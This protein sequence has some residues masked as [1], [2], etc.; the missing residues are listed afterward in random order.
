M[1]QQALRIAFAG[2]PDFAAQH[3]KALLDSEQNNLVAV[4]TQ[5]DRPSGRGKKDK[6]SPV[7]SLALAHEI[8]VYQP[9]NFDSSEQV[10]L[11]ESLQIDVMIVVAYGLL[12]PQYI[13]DIPRFGCLNVHASLLPR[14]RGA[15]P[16]ERAILAGDLET[17]ISIMQMDAGLD[18]GD[19]LLTATTRIEP[20]EN[21]SILTA[22]LITLGCQTLIN[23]LEQIQKNELSPVQQIILE[24]NGSPSTYAKKLHKSEALIDWNRPALEVQRQ[25]NAFFPRSPAY[26]F[27][28]SKRVRIIQSRPDLGTSDTAPGTVVSSSSQGLLIA[29]FESSL[30]VTHVQLEG[31]K[32]NSITDILNGQPD[33]FAPGI[34]FNSKVISDEN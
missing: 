9:L 7:K 32:A 31:K 11:L 26:C 29:C 6:P 22:R 24:Q 30:L 34:K 25:V 21:S 18:T 33:L 20:Q 13:L 1:N 8:P 17:G 23:V 12:L 4:Y 3:L 5:P 15:A 10:A 16:I 19:I 2:T 28:H 27:L 14:W